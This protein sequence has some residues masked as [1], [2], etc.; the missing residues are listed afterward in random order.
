MHTHNSSYMSL[1][2]QLLSYAWINIHKQ[3]VFSVSKID[4]IITVNIMLLYVTQ[5]TDVFNL[6]GKSPIKRAS[7]Y[8]LFHNKPL[9]NFIA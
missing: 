6:W 7:G 4:L 9:Q 1:G 3:N 5:Q 2:S 8:L